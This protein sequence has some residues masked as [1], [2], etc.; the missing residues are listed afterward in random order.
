V[1]LTHF[2]GD[3]AGGCT[4]RMADGTLQ[5]TFPRARYIA[6]RGDFAEASAPNERTAATYASDNWEPLLANGQMT[7]V[8]GPQQLGTQVRTTLAPGHTAALQT[9]WVEAGR[10]SLVFLG[11]ACSWAVHMER[12]AWV[13]A[14]DIFPMTSIESKRTLRQTIMARDTLML[15]QH[16]PQVVTG[17]LIEGARGPEVRAEITRDGWAD[18]LLAE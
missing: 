7:L 16:D 13:P 12:L 18:P 14:Y 9:V 1:L 11:D 10:E 15:F 8:D 5:P 6:Q 3:H 17:R 2:H 4:Q